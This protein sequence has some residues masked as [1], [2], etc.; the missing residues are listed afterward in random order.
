MFP[1]KK[2]NVLE[3][4]S[5][6]YLIYLSQSL[7]LPIWTMDQTNAA[8]IAESYFNN[9]L[10]ATLRITEKIYDSPDRFSERILFDRG[11]RESDL[12]IRESQIRH[13]GNVIG[14][15][16][17]GL[18]KRIYK[19]H[20]RHMLWSSITTMLLIVLSLMLMTSILLRLFMKK[21]LDML[22]LGINQISKGNYDYPFNPVKQKEFR[23]ILSNFIYMANQIQRRE[24]TLADLN[25][26]LEIEVF[27][28]KKVEER[29]S[30]KRSTV[31]IDI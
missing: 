22:M 15:I 25:K 19:E 3:G 18:T 5:N 29:N 23:S 14:S 17:L 7:E 13:N 8:K 27:Q 1:I 30:Q 6:E 24:Q 11:K 21:P 2:K 4:L 28:R 12:L 16:R 26:Q 10:V 20:L 9:D 31:K